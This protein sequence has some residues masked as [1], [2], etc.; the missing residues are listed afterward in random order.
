MVKTLSNAKTVVSADGKT[1]TITAD[2]VTAPWNEMLVTR[3]THTHL[4]PDHQDHVRHIQSS[5]A[6][7]FVRHRGFTFAVP[8]DVFAAIAAVIEPNTTFAPHFRRGTLPPKIEVVSELPM[9]LQ[10]QVSEAAFPMAVAPHTPPPP[11]VWTDVQSQTAASLDESTLKNGQWVRC[12]AT[13]SV[14]TT[15]SQPVKF[16]K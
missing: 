3:V 4:N 5:N 13:N 11:A 16:E 2:I 15:I 12:V 7:V 1:V 8:N 14:G 6:A 10:W 9:T